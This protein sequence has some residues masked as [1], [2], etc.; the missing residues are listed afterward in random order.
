MVDPFTAGFYSE[1]GL[2]LRP[3]Q[4]DIPF[5]ISI[6]VNDRSAT[7]AAASKVIEAMTD[8]IGR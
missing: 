8:L 2:A 4:F 6:I 5:R 3:I 7:G 1:F